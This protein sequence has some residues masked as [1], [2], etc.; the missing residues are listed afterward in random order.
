LKED[1]TVVTW[2]NADYGGDS[3]SVESQLQQVQ[4][5]YAT[6]G[7]FSALKQ[8]GSV[9]TWGFI[10][11]ERVLHLAYHQSQQSNNTQTRI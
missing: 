1:E 11:A 7:S 4:T 9:V 8:D 10:A 3:S 6:N 5:I 2:G